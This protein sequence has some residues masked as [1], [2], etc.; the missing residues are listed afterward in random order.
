MGIKI[1]RIFDKY[2]NTINILKFQYIQNR[3]SKNFKRI[4][5]VEYSY[6]NKLFLNKLFALKDISYYSDLDAFQ[7][8]SYYE[9]TS[10][11]RNKSTFIF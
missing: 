2:I 1:V 10:G 3:N 5:K 11:F 9:R 8:I 7:D 4:S 6:I